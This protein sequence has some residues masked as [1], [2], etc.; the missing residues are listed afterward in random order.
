MNRIYNA[1]AVI[2]AMLAGFLTVSCDKASSPDADPQVFFVRPVD[3]AQGDKLLTEVSMGSTIAVIGEGLAGVNRIAFNDQVSKLNPTLVTPT[4]IIVTVPS[5]MPDEVTNKMYLSTSAGKSTEYDLA[6]IIPSP[7]LQSIECEYAPAG[8]EVSIYGNYFFARESDGLVDV[9]FPGNVAAEVKSVTETEIVCVVPDNANIEGS[10]SVT[11]QYGT[12]RSS[13][14][15]LCSEGIVTDFEET[16]WNNWNLSEF[17][18]E[19]GCSGQYMH[20]SGSVGSCAW[21]A[22]QIQFFYVNPE[23]APLISEGEISEYSL[24]FE[25][26]CNKWDCTPMI[27]WFDADGAHSV[28]NEEAQYHWKLYDEGFEPGVWKTVYIPLTEF[29]MDKEETTTGRTL[30]FEDMVNMSMMP[31]G[32]ADGP[33]AI[34]IMIDNLRLVRN[35]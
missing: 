12:S 28:D 14:S 6:V 13:F 3:S 16:S 15:W 2:A 23:G 34:D 19:N 30:A 8:S 22:N 17:A 9:T 26:C 29:N 35:N 24:V 4:S 33:G 10:I 32:A 27:I 31:F 7:S 20:L 25:Y 11:S 5:T 21:P 18:S 1:A